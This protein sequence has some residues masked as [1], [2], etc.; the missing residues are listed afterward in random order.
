M[1]YAHVFRIDI[2]YVYNQYIYI[3]PIFRC[4]CAYDTHHGALYIPIQLQRYIHVYIRYVTCRKVYIY[5]RIHAIAQVY[6]ITERSTCLFTTI[7]CY[8][9]SGEYTLIFTIID[10]IQHS[11]LDRSYRFKLHL[12]IQGMRVCVRVYACV[13]VCVLERKLQ[14]YQSFD[15]SIGK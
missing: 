3:L 4:A 11:M 12:R 6:I 1:L 13:R 14:F 2:G 7:I 10:I 5:I 9:A 15:R 8:S